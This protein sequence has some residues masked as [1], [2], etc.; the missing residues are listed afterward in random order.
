[1]T[2]VDVLREIYLNEGIHVRELARKLGIGIPSVK[3]HLDRLLKD[4]VVLKKQEG[5]NLKFYL[6]K[7]NPLLVPYLYQVEYAR[8]K[9]LPVSVSNAVFGLISSLENKPVIAAIFGSYSRGTYTKSSDLDIILVFN[10]LADDV[11]K[12]VNIIASRYP[13]RIE[14]VYLTWESFRKKF[15]DEKDGFMKELKSSKIIITGIEYWEALENEK[16]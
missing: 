8:L 12:K 13:V 3:H 11:E 16:A 2:A 7:K 4:R 5:R 6:N 9:E 1:M 10:E 15:F 14:P